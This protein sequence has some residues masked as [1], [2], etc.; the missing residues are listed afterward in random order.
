MP[1]G[2]KSEKATPKKRRDERKKGNIFLSKDAV[3]VVTLLG[4]FAVL[5]V[6]SGGIVENLRNY[7]YLCLSYAGNIYDDSLLLN[8]NTLVTEGILTVAKTVGPLLLVTSVA[9]IGATF[10][11]TRMLVSAESMKPKFERI[12]PLKGFKRLFSLHSVIEALKGILK[13]AVLLYIIYGAISGM[14][15]TFFDYLRTDLSMSCSNL[16]EEIFSMVTSIIIAFVVLAAADFLY[17]WWDYERNMMMTKQEIKD[18][19]KQVEGD[20]QVK[21]KIKE[22][23][24]KMSQSRM[25]QG[26]P[27]ADVVIRNPTHVAV[28]LRYKPTEDNAPIVLAMGQDELALRIV[29]VAEENNVA[30]VENVPLARALYAQSELGMEIPFD[31]YGAVAD[32]MVYIFQIDETGIHK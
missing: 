14:V 25:M 22:A 10:L 32:V 2:N 20:P 16:V 4:S 24:R 28:A 15:S 9:A 19:Y 30:I 26:V 6:F 21:G 17:Q 18:E 12:N 8:L 27:N 31:L 5:R 1:D 23:Q 13:I 29:K 11:Q 7:F 3:S